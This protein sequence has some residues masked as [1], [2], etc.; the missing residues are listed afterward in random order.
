MPEPDARGGVSC[1]A[2]GPAVSGTGGT[3]IGPFPACLA[4]NCSF[5]CKG[6]GEKGG[7][8]S[9]AGSQKPGSSPKLGFG[10]AFER[11]RWL[12][13]VKGSPPLR[14][15]PAKVKR[16]ENVGRVC[17]VGRGWWK[18]APSWRDEES[19]EPAIH[20]APFQVAHWYSMLEPQGRSKVLEFPGAFI[21][22]SATARLESE[23]LFMRSAVLPL[24]WRINTLL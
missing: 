24:I 4:V 20:L 13:S 19:K 17:G 11:R 8:A 15:W 2:A 16:Q 10:N 22:L 23:L 3:L 7:A 21:I 5:E 12:V 18:T 14:G 9:R 1:G 6:V